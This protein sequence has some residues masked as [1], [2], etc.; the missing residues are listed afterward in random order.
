MRYTDITYSTPSWTGFQILISNDVPFL[1]TTVGYLDCIDASATE[2][3]TIYQVGDL[4]K[5][6]YAAQIW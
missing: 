3:S 2:I 5:S 6:I 4:S 1:T